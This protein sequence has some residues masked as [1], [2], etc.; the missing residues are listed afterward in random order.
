MFAL[1]CIAVPLWL[2]APLHQAT[3]AS[4][5]PLGLH[6]TSCT[7]GH[8][9]APAACG[10]FGVY[11]DR[12]AHSGRNLFSSSSSVFHIAQVASRG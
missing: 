2:L 1:C 9:K 4:P 6:L 3:L 10:T 8:S 12:A 11:E 5:S 7:E